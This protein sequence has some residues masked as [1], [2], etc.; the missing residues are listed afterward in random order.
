MEEGSLEESPSVQP[1]L[2]TVVKE[3]FFVEESQSEQLTDKVFCI[4]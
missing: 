2:R 1:E 4:I 3:E